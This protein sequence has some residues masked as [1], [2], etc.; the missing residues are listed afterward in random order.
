M[1]G[2]LESEL[3]WKW[4]G[5][6]ISIE[7]TIFGFGQGRDATYYEHPALSDLLLNNGNTMGNE[8]QGQKLICRH[9]EIS[10]LWSYSTHFDLSKLLSVK[11]P[12]C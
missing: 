4:K 3:K 9:S 10:D 12:E 11:Q 5:Q 6:S 2:N 7:Q 1:M 8:N